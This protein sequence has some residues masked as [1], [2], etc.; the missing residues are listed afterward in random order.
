[1]VVVLILSILAAIAMPKF[2]DIRDDAHTAKNSGAGGAFGAAVSIVHAQWLAGGASGTSVTLEDGTAVGI[3]AE[4]WPENDNTP[5]ANDAITAVE[6]SEVWT[7]VMISGSPTS[8]AVAGS[9]YLSTVVDPTC[10][11]TYQDDTSPARTIT[12]NANTGAVAV[13]P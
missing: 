2:V 11:F 12:Y 1:V 9:D 13:S 7:A 4:G 3:A 6:C 10:T 5:V 8:A